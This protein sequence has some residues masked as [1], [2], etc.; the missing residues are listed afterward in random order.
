MEWVEVK[1]ST[2]DLAVKF[3]LEEL[4]LESREDAEVEVIQQPKAGFLGMGGQDAIVKVSRAPKKRRRRRRGRSGSGQDSKQQPQNADNGGSGQ[5]QSGQGQ[6]RQ[7]GAGQK[8]S[9]RKP[10][11]RGQKSQNKQSARSRQEKQVSNTDAQRPDG[12]SDDRPEQAPIEEQAKVAAGFI[13]G[14]LD[15]FGLEGTVETRIEDDVLY[16]DVEGSQTE[17]LVG[18]KGSVMQSVHELTRTVVQRKTY[19]APR[20]RIDIAGY[21]ARRREALKIYTGKLAEQVIAEE[22]EVMLEPMNAADRKVIHDAVAETEGV[23]SFSEGDEPRRAVVIA[24]VA[25]E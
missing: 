16:I 21:R 23:R 11:S 5:S 19:G 17:A 10:Q 8:S 12:R 24:F 18:T 4:D 7:S 2:V 25:S 3:A 20:M 22:D 15:A 14:L 13:S 6:T 9:N 1:G